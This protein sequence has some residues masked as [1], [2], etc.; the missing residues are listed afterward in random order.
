MTVG[1]PVKL[2][3]GTYVTHGTIKRIE[4]ALNLLTIQPQTLPYEKCYNLTTL[5]SDDGLS[6]VEVVEC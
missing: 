2:R 6:R 3:S 1:D 4:P 5:M